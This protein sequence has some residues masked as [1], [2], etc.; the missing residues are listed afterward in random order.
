MTRPLIVLSEIESGVVVPRILGFIL[1]FIDWLDECSLYQQAVLL[2]ITGTFA[3]LI[4]AAIY[5]SR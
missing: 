5:Y 3:Y 4:A 1:D 2:L